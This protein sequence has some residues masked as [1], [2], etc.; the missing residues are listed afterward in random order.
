MKE[1]LMAR[2]IQMPNTLWEEMM[3]VINDRLTKGNLEK[4]IVFALFTK[5]DD[6]CEIVCY[7]EIPTVRVK[8]DYPNGDYNYIYPGIKALGFYPRKGA[9]KWFSG[10]LVVGDGID[11]EEGERK[12]MVREQM[13]FR[14][15][16]DKNDQGRLSWK[17]YYLDFPSVP[18][19][20]Y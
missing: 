3:R 19:E 16:M 20:F 9:G 15:K 4:P 7:R 6:H 17:A 13:D 5:E 1:Q 10:T 18:L 14:I 12:W 2:T 11:F 8:G